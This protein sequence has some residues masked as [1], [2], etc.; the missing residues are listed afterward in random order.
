[1]RPARMTKTAA[2]LLAGSLALAACASDEEGGNGGSGSEGNAAEELNVGLAFDVGGEGDRSFN[3]S[4]IDGVEAAIEEH[5]GEYTSLEPNADASNRVDLLTE[6]AEAGH[7]PVIAVG[8]SYGEHMQAVA[9]QYPDTTFAVVD[10]PV[11][12][13]GADNLTGL[14]FAANE[15]SYLAGVA[16]ALKTTTNHI[17]FVGGVDVDL[18]KD[19]EAGYIAGA[20]AVKPDIRIDSSYLTALPDLSGFTDPAKGQIAAQGIY[21]AGADIIYHAAGGSGVGVFQAAAASN[22]RAIGVDQDQYESVGD[23]ALQPVIMTS[24]LKRVDLAVE[25]FIGDFVEGNVAGGEDV[26][27]DLSTGG[28]ELATSG[29]FIDDIQDQIEEYRQQIIDGEI[30]VP[31]AE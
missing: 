12:D 7:N 21:D 29:G 20:K 27:N 25:T 14:L 31:Q 1:L 17:G 3:D 6:L 5:G 4:S 23:P 13:L 15:G 9:E 30:E 24:V 18:I 10:A 28:V 19:F 8:F 2:L 26:F 22:K 11:A 16:A